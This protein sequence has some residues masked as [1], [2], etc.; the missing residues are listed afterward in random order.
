M[1]VY[2]TIVG[3]YWLM[4]NVCHW[5]VCMLG[6]SVHLSVIN[7]NSP[8]VPS[9]RWLVLDTES[10]DLVTV[11]T[12]GNEQLSVIRF[13]AGQSSGSQELHVK[14]LIQEQIQRRVQSLKIKI[15]ISQLSELNWCSIYN[16]S[17]K[18]CKQSAQLRNQEKSLPPPA[19]PLLWFVFLPN[20]LPFQFQ[21]KSLLYCWPQENYAL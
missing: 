19:L 12:D 9:H 20:A 10:K 4:I 7:G 8:L 1:H 6:V 13:A 18:F 14:S 5:S 3:F 21:Y 11:H 2:L 15:I 16:N 17:G